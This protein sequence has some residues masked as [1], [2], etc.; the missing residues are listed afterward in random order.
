MLWVRDFPD[1]RAAIMSD[2]TVIGLGS[3]GAA[4]ARVLVTTEYGVTVWNRTPEK[5]DPI[6]AIGANGEANIADALRASPLIMVCIDNYLATRTLLEA[7]DVVHHLSR[8]TLIQFSTGTPKEARESETWMK[9][10][11][12]DYLDVAIRAYPERIGAAD[13]RLLIA[14]PNV[15]FEKYEAVLRCLGGDLRYLGEN[16]GSAAAL[17]LAVLSYSLA[18]HVGIAH[19]THLCEVEGVGVDQFASLFPKGDRAR[20]LAEIVHAE[21]YELQSLYDGASVR[22]WEEVTQ[23]LQAQARDAE[24][25]SELPDFVS[26]IFKRAMSSGLGEEDL[27]ALIKVFRYSSGD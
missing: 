15:V 16:I 18:K 10:C 7:E 25:N 1:E 5:M 13:A 19:A 9:G 23:R 3:M 22:V 11:G 2:I 12:G 21:S 4:L 27:A 26:S 8:R 14:G 6:I 17:D 24:M 20:E